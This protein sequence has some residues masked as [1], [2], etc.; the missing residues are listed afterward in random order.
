MPRTSRTVAQRLAAQK[1]R[2]RRAP[3][4]PAVA[5]SVA[6]ILAE[7]APEPSVDGQTALPARPALSAEVRRGGDVGSASRPVARRR[8]ADYAAE[9]RYVWGDLRR[10][11]LVAGG[12]LL[13]LIVLSLFVG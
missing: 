6:E 1:P 3:R 4:P 11:A 9:Y 8:Y 7:A 12:L 10:I 2:K 13:L 5:P